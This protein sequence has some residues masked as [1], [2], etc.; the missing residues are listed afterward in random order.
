MVIG[1][2]GIYVVLHNM[3]YEEVTFNVAN[4]IAQ[5]GFEKISLP[6][7]TEAFDFSDLTERGTGGFGFNNRE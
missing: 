6:I 1:R 7:L 5:I 4:K 2:G 3:S